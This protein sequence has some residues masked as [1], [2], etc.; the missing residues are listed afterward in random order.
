VG[1]T[2]T[3]DPLA[4]GVMALCVGEA[5]KLVPYLTAHDK[6]YEAVIALGI[7]TDS[8]D[9]EGDILRR[10]AV[11]EVTH[12]R[13]EQVAQTLVGTHPQRPP[14]LS[15]IKIDG[16]PAH[17]RVRRGEA[18]DLP[19]REVT[20]REVTVTRFDRDMLHVTLT[21][22]KGF[23]VRSFARDLA[24]RLGT[25]GHV[26]VLR[27]TRVGGFGLEA[28]GTGAAVGIDLLLDAAAG[29]EAARASLTGSMLSI[30]QAW[31]GAP[32]RALDPQGLEDAR[33]GRR[34]QRD[35]TTGADPASEGDAVVGL[36]DA[37]G[38]LVALARWQ[39]GALRIVRGLW[40]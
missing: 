5:T 27:R 24:E 11:P 16:Q 2:G 33:H 28:R 34:V 1:H 6:T 19:E 8:L 37:S 14:V 17:A 36:L 15:A 13:V 21:C 38:A 32:T 25:V 10:E 35:N 4:S 26:L 30:A 20:L 23:Y 18:V 29:D 22:A 9:A 40:G 39:D 7:E 31:G 3:L 12:A